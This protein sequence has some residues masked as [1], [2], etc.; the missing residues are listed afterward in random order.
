[1]QESLADLIDAPIN[2]KR[3]TLLHLVCCS[4]DHEMVKKLVT[5]G[6][7][8]SI[9]NLYNANC[10]HAAIMFGDV[11]SLKELMKSPGF[12][13][14]CGCFVTLVEMAIVAKSLDCLQ[15]LIDGGANVNVSSSMGGVFSPLRRALYHSNDNDIDIIMALLSAG[16]DID[17]GVREEVERMGDEVFQG[18]LGS[19]SFRLR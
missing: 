4:G 14:H 16:A 10:A 3:E 11:A 12:N 2:D 9:L 6:A 7:D 1:M 18:L 5:L 17:E 15:A 8:V 19:V 13:V